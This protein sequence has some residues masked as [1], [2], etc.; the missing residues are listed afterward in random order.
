MLRTLAISALILSISAGSF[1]ARS[2]AAPSKEKKTEA[3]AAVTQDVSPPKFA[4]FA[5]A[6]ALQNE[7]GAF[8]D[9]NPE[10]FNPDSESQEKLGVRV[11]RIVKR[12][13]IPGGPWATGEIGDFVLENKSIRAIV[14]AKGRE[15]AA[16]VPGAGGIVDIVLR[17]QMWDSLGGLSQFVRID[18]QA[19][20]IAYSDMKIKPPTDAIKTP[21]L[22]LYGTPAGHPEITV[23]TTIR[24]DAEKPHLIVSTMCLNSGKTP[25]KFGLVERAEWG[26]LPV[27]VAAFGIPKYSQEMQFAARWVSGILEDYSL[28]EVTSNTRPL[29][30]ERLLNNVSE[31][32]LFNGALAAGAKAEAERVFVVSPGDMAPASE[33][34]LDTKKLPKGYIDGVVR[35]LSDKKPL[36]GTEIQIRMY[37][38]RQK[39]LGGDYAFPAYAT[40]VTDKDGHYRIAVPP[41]NF[42][43]FSRTAGRPLVPL[44][45]SAQVVQLGGTLEFNIDQMDQKKYQFE[46]VDADTKKPIPAKVVF[47]STRGPMNNPKFGPLWKAQGNRERYYLKPGVNDLPLLAG[48]YNCTFSRGPEYDSVKKLV[49]LGSKESKPVRV[50]LKRTVATSGMVSV[51]INLPTNASPTSRVSAEDLVLAAAAEGVEWVFSGDLNQVTD[52]GKAI[53]AQGL[54]KWVKAS[55]GVHLSYQYQKLFGDFYVFPVPKDTS[56]DVLKKL[57]GP[58]TKPAEFFKAVHTAFPGALIVVMEPQYMNSSYLTYYG[59]DQDTGKSPFADDFSL[60]F[61]GIEALEGK[62]N[63]INHT[64]WFVMVGLLRGANIYRMPLA[65]SRCSNLYFQEVGYPRMYVTVDGKDSAQEL[66]DKDVAGAFRSGRAISLPTVRSSSRL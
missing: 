16:G 31:H 65:S 40:T 63:Q 54:E 32:R 38:E 19:T 53:K 48:P 13:E 35:Q 61:D 27:F 26:A 33:L 66:S 9:L 20:D 39:D 45:M 11:G 1:A 42:A 56:A 43:I 64:N 60:D 24:P 8:G 57:A 37:N 49:V 12:A 14:K 21:S 23:V 46:V 59:M 44:R 28:S 29:A 4:G 47:E 3:P 36:V 25:V 10:T 15:G 62:A 7:A 58:K 5:K 51:D 30:V 52:L 22:A 6:P 34:S 50:E 17:D 41:G 18:G 2:K 55:A